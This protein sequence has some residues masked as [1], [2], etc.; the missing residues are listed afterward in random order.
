MFIYITNYTMVIMKYFIFKLLILSVLYILFNSCSS[1][2]QTKINKEQED[3]NEK[4]QEDFD[5]LYNNTH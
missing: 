1:T 3:Y 2:K 5:E 4:R